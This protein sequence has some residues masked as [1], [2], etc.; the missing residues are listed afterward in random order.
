MGQVRLA[1]V[2]THFIQYRIPLYRYLSK[3]PGLKVTVFFASHAGK[4]AFHDKQFGKKITWDID[5]T[6]DYES[7][8]VGNENTQHLDP[9]EVSTSIAECLHA[10][11]F[12]FVLINGW[13]AKIERQALVCC[14]L[15]GIPI[16]MRPDANE[17]ARQTR[18]QIK[19]LARTVL[20]KLLYQR[21]AGYLAIGRRS[22][23]HFKKFGGIESRIYSSPHSVDLDFFSNSSSTAPQIDKA[24]SE[25]DVGPETFILL[26]CGKLIAKK[27][28]MI[29][30]DAIKLLENEIPLHVMMIGDGEL[31]AELEKKKTEFKLSNISFHGFKNQ[32]ELPKYYSMC[33][34]LILPS[35]GETWG[36]VVNEAMA[37]G[38][39]VLVSDRVGCREDLIVAGKTG[40]VFR[41]DSAEDLAE[42]V[43]EIFRSRDQV[44]R[45]GEMAKRHIE[46]FSIMHSAKG[47]LK[48][49]N[50]ES[51]S[52]SHGDIQTAS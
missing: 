26:F 8:F 7:K 37:C 49:M 10:N 36:L 15:R 18:S 44:R 5:L 25:I 9:T 34:A 23:Q 12:D 2:E 20:L 13:V 24:R 17:E 3:I 47:I 39:P 21:I 31:R 14:L 46:N 28:P 11:M 51:E 43:R 29:I 1:I 40:F 48:A 52:G 22:V 42:K 6:S 19:D 35:A 30:L 27:N 45:M 41:H 16:L 38:K 32:T 50:L 33:D 4:E